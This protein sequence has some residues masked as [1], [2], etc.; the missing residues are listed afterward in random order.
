M[1]YTI[2]DP[3]TE[4]Y[5]FVGWHAQDK[6]IAIGHRGSSNLPNWSVGGA[7][8]RGLSAH[9][10]ASPFPPGLA[11]SPTV[12]RQTLSSSSGRIP[13]LRARACTAA[14]SSAGRVR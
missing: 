2:Y 12:G 5:G 7:S 9:A 13:A 3:K 8:V 14:F 6:Y 10:L 11:A 1:L 4:A